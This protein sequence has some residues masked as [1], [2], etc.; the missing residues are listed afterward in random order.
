MPIC[1]GIN[2]LDARNFRIFTIQ[3]N[4]EAE[5]HIRF[6]RIE[7]IDDL[8]SR[9]FGPVIRGGQGDQQ[10][11]VALPQELTSINDG[12]GLEDGG[13]LIAELK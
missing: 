3:E 12:F 10:I 11:E 1:I 13:E 5:Q 6:Y 8:K 2:G 4:T 9:L 7:L